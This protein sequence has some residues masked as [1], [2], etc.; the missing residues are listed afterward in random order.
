MNEDID[1]FILKKYEIIQKL[2]TGKKSIIWKA[3]DRDTNT[4]VALKKVDS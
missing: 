3:V 2:N 4:L 1:Q